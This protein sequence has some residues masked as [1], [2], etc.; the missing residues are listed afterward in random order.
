MKN[1][2]H[3]FTGPHRRG[4]LWRDPEIL[5]KTSCSTRLCT[6]YLNLYFICYS[7]YTNASEP[8]YNVAKFYWNL[9]RGLRVKAE[10]TEKKSE[11]NQLWLVSCEMP[12]KRLNSFKLPFTFL[13]VLTV[14]ELL[15]GISFFYRFFESFGYFYYPN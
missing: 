13:L 3:T 11:N 6:R 12:K 10:Q 7:T 14:R 5:F 4:I 1:S 2:T 9:M 8:G 15:S